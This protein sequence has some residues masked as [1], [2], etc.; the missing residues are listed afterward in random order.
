MAERVTSGWLGLATM[1][2]LTIAGLALAGFLVLQSTSDRIIAGHA[3]ETALAWAEYVGSELGTIEAAAAGKP[4]SAEQ[5]EFLQGVTRFGPVFRFKLFDGDG[6]LIIV[7][8]DLDIGGAIAER[9][10][11]H[12]AKARSVVATGNP[13][14]GVKSGVDKP[15]RPDVYAESYVPVLNFGKVVAVTEVYVDQTL[16]A[17]ATRN[18]FILFGSIIAGFTLLALVLP[19]VGLFSLTQKMR[20][21]NKIL[22]EEKERALAAERAKSEF[23][24]NMSHEIR[25]PL[26]GV[27][28]MASLILD[29]DPDETQRQYTETII[30]SGESLLTILNDILDFSKIEQNKLELEESEFE[31]VSL[32]DNTAALLAPQAHSKGLEIPTYVAPDIPRRLHGDEGRIRQIL[33]NLVSNAIKFTETGAV[34]VS[35]SALPPGDRSNSIKLRFEVADTGIGVPPDMRS[36]IFEQFTQV[37]QSTTRQFGGTG[38]GLAICKR[39]VSLMDGDIGV[40]PRPQGGSLFW[41]T[42]CL[43]RGSASESWSV[44]AGGALRHRKILVVDDNS[45]NRTIFE[46]QLDGLGVRVAVAGSAEAAIVKLQAAA[47]EGASFDAAIIDHLMPGTDGVELAATIREAPWGRGLRLVLS[48]SASLINTDSGARQHGFDK[49]LPKPLRPGAL[50]RCVTG[51]FVDPPQEVV[52]AA[53]PRAA[54]PVDSV[55]AQKRILLAEDNQVNQ[56]LTTAVVTAAGYDINVV[57][58]GI[59][60]VEALRTRPYSLVLMDIQMPEMDGIDATRLIRQLS[61]ENA[62][63]PIIGV[64]A[65]AMKGD[66]ERFMQAGMN[67]Y[68][69]KPIDTKMLAKRIA[70]WMGDDELAATEGD[71]T[72]SSDG[73]EEA[74]QPTRRIEEAG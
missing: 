65:Y 29:T 9:N 31:L 66:Q 8:D 46:K 57:A 30:Q 63:I 33:L 40:E 4:L 61:N 3:E 34:T 58:N 71:L 27:L 18:D 50:I 64:T 22:S 44:A 51:L 7:S 55:V 67:D 47:E 2:G 62:T 26:N 13:V 73:P 14:T 60:A 12:N 49:A 6:R 69:S 16:Q 48:S 59:E 28:G 1:I 25:T 23:L 38:L 41:F 52:P 21:Q 24:A 56:M 39:L 74:L 17:A 5:R 72:A 37:D 43:E 35:V 19:F 53:T 42:L 70:F 54:E 45:I 10:D 11:D 20:R 36:R 32:L 68:M 15:D